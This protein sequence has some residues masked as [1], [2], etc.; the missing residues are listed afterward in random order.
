MRAVHLVH[1][2][3]CTLSR[4]FSN[5]WFAI[6]LAFSF[7]LLLS[8]FSPFFSFCPSF[9]FFPFFPLFCSFSSLPSF[10]SFSSFSSFSSSFASSFSSFSF[11]SFCSFSSVSCVS[12][13]SY[14]RCFFFCLTFLLPALSSLVFS[15]TFAVTLASFRPG[16]VSLLLLPSSFFPTPLWG[17]I[18][19]TLQFP[20]IPLTLLETSSAAILSLTCHGTA[21]A[22]CNQGN[23]KLAAASKAW[24]GPWRGERK[25]R[26]PEKNVSEES[27][28]NEILNSLILL[29]H[30]GW[31]FCSCLV[32]KWMRIHFCKGHLKV[33]ILLSNFEL[34]PKLSQNLCQPLPI[35]EVLARV[36]KCQ[37]Y[38]L[39]IPP[40]PQ[41]FLSSPRLEF[42][43]MSLRDILLPFTLRTSVSAGI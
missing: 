18:L 3:S 35:R 10:P 33:A 28:M 5:M 23:P 20:L 39:R 21:S 41:S 38:S 30:V 36:N 43:S 40:P 34:A 7:R 22:H 16:L 12:C 1:T 2:D 19:H 25:G 8:T 17:I 9:S 13:V 15:V 27:L 24:L 29:L 37:Q 4:F 42:F 6:F 14:L 32:R 26:S 31:C 11:S